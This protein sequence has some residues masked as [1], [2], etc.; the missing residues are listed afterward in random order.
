VVPV[1]WHCGGSDSASVTPACADGER[2]GF[3]D[4]AA[5]PDIAG[6]AGGWSLAGVTVELPPGC[7]ASG[8]D[9]DNLRGTG[10]HIGDLCAPGWHV[11]ASHDEVARLA[12]DCSGAT[13]DLP[14]ELPLFFAQRRSGG[15]AACDARGAN[16]LYG[17]GNIGTPAPGCA[18][19]QI[20][21]DGCSSLGAPW[22]CPSGEFEANRVL[23]SGPE[24]GGALCCRDGAFR[25]P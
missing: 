14:P 12:G 7:E 8:D 18:P 6:C 1:F 9:A 4:A 13:A 19:L 20:S 11:C 22:S 5:F 17:C 25:A 24:V 16:D 23:K 3:V 2:D 15:G 10:C 21:G